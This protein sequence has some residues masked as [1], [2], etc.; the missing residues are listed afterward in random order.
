MNEISNNMTYE[1]FFAQDDKNDI[2]F[3]FPM[4]GMIKTLFGWI[5]LFF[6]T[7]LAADVAVVPYSFSGDVASRSFTLWANGQAIPVA[8]VPA[9]DAAER[10]RLADAYLKLP[11]Y[12]HIYDPACMHLHFAHLAANDDVNVQV[13]V[14]QTIG[15]FNIY[16]IKEKI[17]AKKSDNV[18]HFTV[19]RKK[20]PYYFIIRIDQL[21]PLMLAIDRLETIRAASSS[22]INANSFLTDATGSMDQTEGMQKAFDAANGTGKILYVPSGVYLIDQ[23]HI[24]QG[25]DFTIYLAPG[26]LFKVRPSAGREN[27]HRHG[28]WLQDC[29]N[30]TVLGPGGI[31][32][33]AYEHYALYQNNYQDGMVDYYTSN[34]L[35]PWI[36]QSPLFITGS[37]HILVDGLVI[38]NGR[39][40]NINARGCDDLTL[41]RIKILTPPACTP[42]YADGINTSS[43][44]QVLVEDCLV[45]CNDDCFAS[46]HYFATW[47]HRASADHI[48]RRMLGWNM[49][50]DAVRLGFYAAFDQGDFTF[51]ECCFVAMPFGSVLIHALRPQAEGKVS[52]YGTIRLINCTFANAERLKVL[53]SVDKAAINNLELKD[54]HFAGK[55]PDK[56]RFVV[57]GDP[58]SPIGR[59]VLDQ[60]KF[61]GKV[62]ADIRE[63]PAK[64]S[65]INRIIVK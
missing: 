33:Q 37:Q 38:R 53:F 10:Q 48:V 22:I 3:R 36:S 59:L 32:Q 35:C 44:R 42:E 14:G 8:E 56:A 57:E 2:Y 15:E 55:P 5:M 31:D 29:R 13:K 21:P 20:E 39:N 46:G 26:C 18:L 61:N 6:L 27:H 49:R 12:C 64:I 7:T 30:L 62:V 41:R 1:L 40:F 17:A 43:C 47:D 4:S 58:A 16:T 63:L 52:R 54:V 9:M 24:V 51:E 11:S 23:L 25:H 34:E 60:V 65:N 50:A 45:A 28:L 19:R